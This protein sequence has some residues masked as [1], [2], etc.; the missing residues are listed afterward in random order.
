MPLSTSQVPDALLERR[1]GFI[2]LRWSFPD[3]VG[4]P[5]AAPAGVGGDTLAGGLGTDPM[6]GGAGADRFQL[7]TL[8]DGLINIQTIAD[9]VSG[10]DVIENAVAGRG[11]AALAPFIGQTIGVETTSGVPT[12]A[13]GALTHAA[14]AGEPGAAVTIAILSGAPALGADLLVAA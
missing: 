7:R 10:V 12:H 3:A 5:V 14:D 13:G 8:I 9:F 4:S 1:R 2:G 6:T 11:M